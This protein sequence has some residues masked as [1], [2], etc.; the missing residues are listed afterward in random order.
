M[1]YYTSIEYT[2]IFLDKKHFEDVYNKM[3]KLNDYDELKSGGMFGSV[4]PDQEKSKYNPTKW[5][6]WMDY[7]YP[8]TCKDMNEI[9]EALGFDVL[10]DNEGNLIGLSYYNKTGSEDYFMSCF[11]GFVKDESVI[12]W[13]GEENEDYYRYFFKDGKMIVQRAVVTLDYTKDEPEVYEFGKMSKSD[14]AM[15]EWRKEWQLKKAAQ[16]LSAS[17]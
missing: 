9:L 14:L 10:Y 5:F 15:E 17:D 13:K 4:K 16:E 11:A 7:N 2:N 1:G 6:S 12:D 3:C 8:E